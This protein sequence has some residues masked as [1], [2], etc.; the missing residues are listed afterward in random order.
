M[1]SLA[2]GAEGG[3]KARAKDGPAQGQAWPQ[4]AKIAQRNAF[5]TV[6]M[7]KSFK[8][9]KNSKPASTKATSPPPTQAQEL[10]CGAW[11]A[12]PGVPH[13]PLWAGYSVLFAHDVSAPAEEPA[14]ARDVHVTAHALL[15]P[16]SPPRMR[17]RR[18]EQHL[19]SPSPNTRRPNDPVAARR[20]L[21]SA[22]GAEAAA[23]PGSSN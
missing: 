11:P 18:R 19:P 16:R 4:R 3:P 7:H 12:P 22:P 9:L 17:Q 21:G 20:P 8:L 13:I 14:R 23:F 1:R 5:H 10:P 6:Q 2:R 15:P